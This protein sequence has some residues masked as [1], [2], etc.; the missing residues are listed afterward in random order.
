MTS[1]GAPVRSRAKAQYFF[2]SSFWDYT[3][4]ND[5]GNIWM[6]FGNEFWLILCQEYKNS[7]LFAVS[8]DLWEPWS[9]SCDGPMTNYLIQ[10]QGAY[11]RIQSIFSRGHLWE[12]RFKSGFH[13]SFW[14]LVVPDRISWMTLEIYEWNFLFNTFISILQFYDSSV[15][16]RLLLT[17]IGRMYWIVQTTDII[18]KWTKNNKSEYQILNHRIE[19]QLLTYREIKIEYQNFKL[20]YS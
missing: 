7:K 10:M 18:I 8:T 2:L 14:D 17:W 1:L 20:K 19:Y 13:N 11:V 3:S 15:Q 5:F 4:P 12:P 6:N 9:S 16:N